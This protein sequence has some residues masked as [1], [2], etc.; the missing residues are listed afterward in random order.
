M[1]M[2]TSAKDYEYCQQAM[3]CNELSDTTLTVSKYG[4]EDILL[5]K[6]KGSMLAGKVIVRAH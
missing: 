3:K 1:V 4:R 2:G 6:K 5:V